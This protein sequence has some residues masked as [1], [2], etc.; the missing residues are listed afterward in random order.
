MLASRR[1][2][3]SWKLWLARE[4]AHDNC[5]VAKPPSLQQGRIHEGTMMTGLKSGCKP[6]A[7]RS[8]S[9]AELHRAQDEL[10]TP[11][12]FTNDGKSLDHPS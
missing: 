8:N 12:Y 5:R 11:H 10:R 6:S 4:K 9:F 7:D 2:P 3:Y 1:S